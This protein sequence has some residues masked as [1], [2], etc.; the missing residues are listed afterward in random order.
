MAPLIY[1]SK[2]PVYLRN[3]TQPTLS[4][5]M[6]LNYKRVKQLNFLNIVTLHLL[7]YV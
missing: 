1:R 2:M 4:T 6:Y 7:T 5:N 3:V